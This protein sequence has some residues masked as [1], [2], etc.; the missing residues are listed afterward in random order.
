V[1]LLADTNGRRLG[2]PDDEPR[3][4]AVDRDDAAARFPAH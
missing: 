1:S 2:E 3:I 4:A